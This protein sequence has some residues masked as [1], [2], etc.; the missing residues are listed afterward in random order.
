MS[1]IIVWI[2]V[3]LQ[4]HRS[5]GS[6]ISDFVNLMQIRSNVGYLALDKVYAIIGFLIANTELA[7]HVHMDLICKYFNNSIG[8]RVLVD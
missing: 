1:M 6:L 4:G 8:V 2:T 5:F 7:E 3:A